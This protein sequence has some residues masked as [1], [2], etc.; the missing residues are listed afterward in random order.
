MDLENWDVG[1][2]GELSAAR[3]PRDSLHP[4]A[5]EDL[6]TAPK[7]TPWALGGFHRTHFITNGC[8]FFFLFSAHGLGAVYA[9]ARPNS[10]ASTRCR[11]CRSGR[12]RSGPQLSSGPDHRRPERRVSQERMPRRPQD[13]DP[14]ARSLPWGLPRAARDRSSPTTLACCP[15]FLTPRASL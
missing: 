1:A 9:A 13:P 10:A 3:E 8:D 2:N 6:K 4:G 14:R 5:T 12:W 7:T 11:R 15:G